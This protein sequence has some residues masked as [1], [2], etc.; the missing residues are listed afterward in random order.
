MGKRKR[1]LQVLYFT[2]VGIQIIVLSLK[3]TGL[4]LHIMPLSKGQAT[5]FM[6]KIEDELEGGSGDR[7]QLNLLI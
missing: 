4:L 2:F 1:S 6:I 5:I 7:G 3:Q